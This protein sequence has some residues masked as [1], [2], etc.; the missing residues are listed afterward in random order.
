MSNTKLES[1]T[2]KKYR[3]GDRA[4]L[5]E[6]FDQC[7]VATLSTVVD[8]E[9]WSVPMLTVRDGERLLLHGSTGAGA[10]RHVSRGANV[11]VSAFILDGL[12]IAERQFNHSANYRSAVVRGRCSVVDR[13][14]LP[15]A[16]DMF[17]DALVDGRSRECPPHS[18]KELA[19]TILLALPIVDGMWLAK[20]RSGSTGEESPTWT[21]VI[22]VE[23]RVGEPIPDA[24][25]PMP[26]SVRA[27]VGKHT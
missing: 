7:L 22:P 9:P 12:V 3:G 14:E 10:L 21:G 19:Q 13:A 25:L 1:L 27:L 24:D 4:L 15:R 8:D 5:D 16:L 6:V 23:S 2:R 20:Q 18:D 17:T 11:A 26:E